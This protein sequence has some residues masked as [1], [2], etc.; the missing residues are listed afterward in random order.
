MNRYVRFRTAAGARYGLLD[1]ETIRELAGD[2]FDNPQPTGR[3]V[4]LAGTELLLP[5][6]PTRVQKIIG[7]ALNYHRPGAPP[8]IEHPRWFAKLTSALNTHEGDV[9]LPPDAANMNFEGEL[10]LII[11]KKGRRIPVEEADQYIFGATVGN[12]W[13]ENT[14]FYERKLYEEPSQ[15]IAKSIDTWACLYTTIVTGLDLT[16]L[17]IETRMNGEVVARG[18]TSNMINSPARLVSYFSRYVTLMPGDVIYTGRVAP[19]QPGTRAEMRDGDVVE[20]AID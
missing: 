16:N 6:D 17:A 5:L 11:G 4:P 18:H 9:E 12:D 14:W 8:A 15:M 7:V 1:G 20:V 10:V 19:P 13:S 3:T 2:L